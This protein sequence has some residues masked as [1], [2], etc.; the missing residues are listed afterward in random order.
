MLEGIS[1]SHLEILAQRATPQY[2]LRQKKILPRKLFS[3]VSIVN[4]T[5]LNAQSRKAKKRDI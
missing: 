2:H 5:F 3:R 4:A 1:R